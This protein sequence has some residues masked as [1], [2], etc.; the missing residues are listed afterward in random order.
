MKR[1]PAHL[2][3]QVSE[4]LPDFVASTRMNIREMASERSAILA[5]NFRKLIKSATGIHP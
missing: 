3:N 1:A 4:R 2:V 5:G